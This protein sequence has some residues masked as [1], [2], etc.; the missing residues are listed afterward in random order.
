MQKVLLVFFLLVTGNVCIFTENTLQQDGNTFTFF[1]EDKKRI[2]TRV[3]DNQ[4]NV[5][6]TDGTITD[7]KFV[8]YSEEGKRIGE[9]HYKGGLRE[10]ITKLYYESEKLYAEISYKKGKKNGPVEYYYEN[11]KP[12]AEF[13]YANGVREDQGKAYDMAGKLLW[14][15]QYKAGKLNGTYALYY[16]NGKKAVL[17]TYAEGK[18]IEKKAFKNNGTLIKKKILTLYKE[19]AAAALPHS[20]SECGGGKFITLSKLKLN[21]NGL[22]GSLQVDTVQD[23][24]FI[25]AIYI[26]TPTQLVV[27][28]KDLEKELMGIY[29]RGGGVTPLFS[30]RGYTLKGS[31]RK[32]MIEFSVIGM[33]G[34]IYDVRNGPKKITI[35]CLDGT[36]NPH[37]FPYGENGVFDSISN[38]LEQDV[39]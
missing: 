23:I 7:G 24:E 2:A 27:A 9:Y 12:M 8:E 31:G 19:T 28:Y 6:S 34:N 21:T 35:F 14:T 18:L 38:V 39:K 4:G 20:V 25:L 1:N 17:E 36:V 33:S 30:T 11:G 13:T 3:L 32:Q 15:A 5:V 22:S 37:S 10:G 29:E 26:K 16:S